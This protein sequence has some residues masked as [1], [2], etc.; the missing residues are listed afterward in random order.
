VVVSPLPIFT[1]ALDEAYYLSDGMIFEEAY[2]QAIHYQDWNR[3]FPEDSSAE[4]SDMTK[5]G[6]SEFVNAL[7]LKGRI[8]VGCAGNPHGW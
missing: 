2:T 1:A 4:G 3:K 7:E 8:V 6:G 5:P